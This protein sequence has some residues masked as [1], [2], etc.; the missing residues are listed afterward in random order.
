M[1][2]E[3]IPKLTDVY[4]LTVELVKMASYA[5]LSYFSYKYSSTTSGCLI[6]E[7]RF[8]DAGLSE[9]VG[10]LKPSQKPWDMSKI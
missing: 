5:R 7:M 6:L 8:L 10:F 9:D 1:L 4:I 3:D 2:L